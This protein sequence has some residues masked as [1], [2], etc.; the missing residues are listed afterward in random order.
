MSFNQP[1]HGV[2]HTS[3]F[4]G[5]VKLDNKL[6][7]AVAEFVIPCRRDVAR[8]FWEADVLDATVPA[9]TIEPLTLV[10]AMALVAML[11]VSFNVVSSP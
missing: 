5:V 1:D 8:S 6:H 2:G 10:R 3:G 4:G 11:E 9:R 7:V